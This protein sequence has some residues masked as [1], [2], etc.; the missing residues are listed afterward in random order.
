MLRKQPPNVSLRCV[1][2]PNLLKIYHKK[3]PHLPAALSP[4]GHRDKMYK[5][6]SGS[7]QVVSNAP[8]EISGGKGAHTGR[9]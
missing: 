6:S 7:Y 1:Q 5:I 3:A 2:V 4:A 8:E 9:S